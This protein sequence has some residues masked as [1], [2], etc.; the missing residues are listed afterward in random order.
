MSGTRANRNASVNLTLN[1]RN[2]TQAKRS[3]MAYAR[4]IRAGMARNDLTYAALADSA[5]VNTVT[6][7]SHM[8]C[9]VKSPQVRTMFNILFALGWEEISI[10]KDDI[11]HRLRKVA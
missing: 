8:N 5:G 11:E 3:I 10:T 7:W 9:H 4:E 2:K 6:I 1:F